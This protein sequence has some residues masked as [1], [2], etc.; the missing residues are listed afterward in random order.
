MGADGQHV[1]VPMNMC[2]SALAR[3][4]Y[5]VG[6]D[7]K[8]LKEWVGR[9]SLNPLNII[10]GKST[11]VWTDFEWDGVRAVDFV[12]EAIVGK[13]SFKCNGVACGSYDGIVGVVR[14]PL[15]GL[16]RGINR[17]EIEVQP[18]RTGKCDGV[19]LVGDVYVEYGGEVHV[20]GVAIHTGW[21]SATVAAD[22]ELANRGSNPLSATIRPY[23]VEE[24]R[25]RLRLPVKELR[26]GPGETGTVHAVSKWAN[27]KVW[28]IGGKY[29]NPDLYELV[30]DVC[31]D[32]KVVDR[33]REVFGF[34][35]F[36][37]Y[38]TEFFLNGR[39][40]V[41]QGDT[42]NLHYKMQ[43]VRDVVWN[44]LREDGI[45]VIRTHGDSY[46]SVPLVADADRMGMLVYA[47][48]YPMLNETKK[49]DRRKFIP[50]EKWFETDTHKWNLEN[51][52]RWWRTFRN[53]PSVVVWST[54]NEILTQAWDYAADAEYNV[55]SDRLAAFYGKYVKSFDRSLVM[56]RDGDLGTLNRFQRW[57][58]DP[59]CDTANYHYPD[60]DLFATVAN[61]RK[62]YE[63]RPAIWGETL[64]CSYGAWDGWVGPIPSQVEKKAAR[65]RRVVSFY[66][67]EE[68][69]GQIF[70][71]LG[72]DGYAQQDDTGKGNPWGI[73]ASAKKRYEKDGCLPKGLA[74]RTFPWLEIMWPS[75][76]GSG[77]RPVAF[78]LDAWCYT[79][80]L[81]NCFDSER[82]VVV[83][84]AVAKAYR[85][86]LLPQPPVRMGWSAEALVE[87]GAGGMPVWAY[88]ADGRVWGVVAD[89]EGRAWFRRLPPGAYRIVSGKR[90]C[91]V[92][93][94]YDGR[95]AFKPGFESVVKISLV[96][97]GFEPRGDRPRERALKW[98]AK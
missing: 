20:E 85:D 38:H 92:T 18:P 57:Y 76:S 11:I 83:R 39:R 95:A 40:I 19:G 51:Y 49:I 58:E 14:I 66:R 54:D 44:I 93:I 31:V 79:G 23:V 65:V 98:C 74:P 91:R 68:V 56:T 10:D 13:A 86:V 12:S 62:T 28:G 96:D 41:L 77:P 81:I 9:W 75:L 47:Q 67:D 55:R 53:H 42:G 8:P 69:S 32:G 30:T 35:E 22:I 3:F 29:G 46:W 73:T 84:N 88:A 59:P 1:R 24:G 33:Q 60:F 27:P 2:D 89:A 43:R 17:L 63:W 34:R 80:N 5:P 37:I 64:Y 6:R 82:P 21:E 48:M 45:N 70:M 72:M 16:R 71:G 4:N 90:E 52:R 25:I 78:R 87:G 94:A 26:L 50:Y 97:N 15:A 36:R 7:G 61:W